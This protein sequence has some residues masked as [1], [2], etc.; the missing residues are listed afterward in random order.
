MV[1]AGY[2]ERLFAGWTPASGQLLFKLR[3][4]GAFDMT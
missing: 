3:P 1:L 4:F 2:P